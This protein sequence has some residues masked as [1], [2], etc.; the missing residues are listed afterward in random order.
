MRQWLSKPRQLPRLPR[1]SSA[2]GRWASPRIFALGVMGLAVGLLVVIQMRSY[3]SVTALVER[4]PE[5]TTQEIFQQIYILKLANERLENDILTLEE[6]LE[7]YSDQT[8]AYG[9]LVAEIEKNEALL[10]LKPIQG[11]AIVIAVDAPLTVEWLVDLTNELWAAG[12]EAVSVNGIRLTDSTDGFYAIN[13]LLL[14]Q[15]QILERPYTWAAVGDVSTLQT[16]L[17]QAGG[18]LKRLEEQMGS[19]TLTVK[20]AEIEML[21]LVAAE[22]SPS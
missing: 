17:S 6:Q 7:Q 11:P 21:A 9:T 19:E 15:G 13:E 16:V 20:E 3:D 10:G 12:A 18:I 2:F 14:L 5:T 4:D 22:D 1:P 8:S